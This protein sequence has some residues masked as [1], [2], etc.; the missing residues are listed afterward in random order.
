MGYLGDGNTIRWNAGIAPL[1]EE[2]ISELSSYEQPSGNRRFTW[3]QDYGDKLNLY[4][5]NPHYIVVTLD[6]SKI[7]KSEDGEN[8]FKPTIYLDGKKEIDAKYNVKSWE[9]FKERME[10]NNDKY[11]II[12]KSTQS[13]G[14]SWHYSTLNAYCLRLYSR[15]LNDNEVQENHD[16]AVEYHS[17]LTK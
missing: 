11:F 10:I 6:T 7:W 2:A 13:F 12:G 15:A 8:Y 5:G 16:K 1:G 17:L 14:G 3:N 9:T 4:D